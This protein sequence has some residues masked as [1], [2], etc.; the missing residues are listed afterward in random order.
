MSSNLCTLKQTLEVYITSDFLT[1]SYFDQIIIFFPSILHFYL[2]TF[3]S[4]AFK[5]K[6]SSQKIIYN[7]FH[8]IFLIYIY[9]LCI[10]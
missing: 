6:I 5:L 10:M 4:F 7:K 8:L 1:L 9:F 3:K 2:L